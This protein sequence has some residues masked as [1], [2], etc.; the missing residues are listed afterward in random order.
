ME[1]T[2][3]L[4][5]KHH[6]TKLFYS[7]L[8]VTTLTA[9][10]NLLFEIIDVNKEIISTEDKA[11]IEQLIDVEKNPRISAGWAVNFSNFES[12]EKINLTVSLPDVNSSLQPY[13]TAIFKADNTFNL[14]IDFNTIFE[15]GTYIISDKDSTIERTSVYTGKWKIQEF[16]Q[17]HFMWKEIGEEG[18]IGQR[19]FK[20]E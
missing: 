12:K 7:I 20:V 1:F 5:P 10:E 18:P 2:F 6:E 9:Q 13:I 16:S 15:E 14:A 19:Y 11:T 8:L 4:K 17:D 3:F